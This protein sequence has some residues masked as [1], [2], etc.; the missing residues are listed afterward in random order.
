MYG[1][2]SDLTMEVCCKISEVIPGRLT[3]GQIDLVRRLLPNTWSLR[4]CI[5]D[6]VEFKMPSTRI[7]W[8]R[9]Y[10]E[11]RSLSWSRAVPATLTVHI[12]KECRRGWCMPKTVI[13]VSE[14]AGN[15]VFCLYHQP[16]I[17]DFTRRWCGDISIRN[18]LV[19]SSKA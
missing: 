14:I 19:V 17:H 9:V 7:R 11:C 16:P 18:R 15:Q 3:C 2:F 6:A 4:F 5:Y 13:L 12:H 10:R 1:L 8:I